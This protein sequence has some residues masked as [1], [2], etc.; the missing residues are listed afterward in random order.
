MT[1][2]IERWF[3]CAEVSA[4]AQKGWGL[5]R[6][7]KAVFTWFAARPPAQAKAAVI[8]SLLPWPESE[9]EQLRLQELVKGALRGR[10]AEREA[11]R[12][13]IMA[14]GVGTIVLDPFSGR[15]MIP[16][17]AAR[18]GLAS[19]CLDYAPVAVL[20]S[21]LLADFPFRDWTGEPPI[22]FSDYDLSGPPHDR[23]LADVNG[24]LDE[25]GRRYSETME[26]FYPE[27]EG[28]RPWGYVWAVTLPCLECGRRF[29]LIGSY[30]LRKAGSRR[31]SGGGS[32]GDCGQSY[33][34][35]ASRDTGELRVVVHDGPPRRTPTLTSAI[36]ADGRRVRGKAAVCSFCGHVHP[37]PV[38]QRL[39]D[40]RLGEDVLLVVA[41]SEPRAGKS[42][43]LPTPVER[44]A[45][46]AAKQALA[47]ERPFSPILSALPDEA[48]PANNG[49]TIRPQLYGAR[50]YGELMCTRQALGFVR[51]SRIIADLGAELTVDHG[52]SAEYARALTGYAGA[53]LAREVRYATRG[54][55]LYVANQQVSD[56]FLN[57]GA[58][59]FSYD[60]FE[61][62][63]GDGAGTW[64]SLAGNS[65]TTI[66]TVLADGLG[67]PSSVSRGTARDLPF[68]ARTVTAVVTDP[69]YDAMVYY[70]DSS[71][72]LYVWLKRALHGTWPDLASTADPRGLQEKTDE[73]VVKEHG[74]A[75]GEHRTRAFY[76]RG[77]AEAF[78]EMSRVVE[79]DGIVT[80]V[81][82]HGEPEVWQRLLTALTAAN[83]V[84]TGS[85]PANTEAGG[86][87][88]KANIET[89]LTMA[90]RPATANRPV[91][92][93]AA[94]EAEIRSAIRSRYPDWERWGL[95][96]T[97][98]LMAAAGPA[99]E[100]VGRYSE[101]LD[102]RGR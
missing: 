33:Y 10:Y 40:E 42:Y 22:P 1:R 49:A 78:A 54:A 36:A 50:T 87:Q 25:V 62:G 19:D 71:D 58:I 94:V 101:V 3:P 99:M 7:E 28:R 48:I 26:S 20:A 70:T 24:V 79:E 66:R 32:G 98:M 86:Q 53:N 72:L 16:L 56:V 77:I 27:V 80:I 89:T 34:V 67:H 57:E 95:A 60:F 73:L 64:Q 18:L 96:P 8:C 84:L 35:E 17:E 69:P 88:G 44:A 41:D 30:E 12:R 39:A 9:A 47:D 91:G 23:F 29:P 37:L 83:L 74:K 75:P 46:D 4:A 43:R 90:C 97:D 81:F 82:G 21:S 45:V 31:S 102:N 2:M 85:W 59:A 100:I 55:T 51:L 14:A 93:K 61:T 52:I 13:E 38:H 76:D 65:R 11:L 15:G 63:L 6:A 68:R 92:R 5:G